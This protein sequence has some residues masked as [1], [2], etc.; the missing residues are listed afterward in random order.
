[1][2]EPVRRARGRCR[3][4]LAWCARPTG[5]SHALT[6]D[7]PAQRFEGAM[8]WPRQGKQ[9]REVRRGQQYKHYKGRD[10]VEPRPIRVLLLQHESNLHIDL[11]ANYVA[12]LYQDV[13]VLNPCAFHASKRLGSTGDSLVYG[14]LEARLGRGAQLCYSGNTHRYQSP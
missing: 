8:R 10:P 2:I 7:A 4:R 1:M 5:G 9:A 11:V 3:Y 14:V 12:V 6:T 13:L